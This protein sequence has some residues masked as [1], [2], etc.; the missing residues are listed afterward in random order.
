MKKILL[1]PILLLMILNSCEEKKSVKKEKELKQKYSIDIENSSVNWTAYKTT[2]KVAVKGTFKEVNIENIKSESSMIDAINGLEF[3]IPVTSIYS[4][5]TIRDAKLVKFFFGN[6]DNSM[7]LKGE[8]HLDD[9]EGGSIAFTMN[10][11]T[12][13]LPIT[14][15]IDNDIMD[16]NGVMDL[17]T[18]EAKAAI[19]ILKEACFELHKGK[20]GVSKTWEEI[21]V[22][23]KLKIISNQ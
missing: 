4:K 15:K 17:N 8:L 19:A 1:L 20:D 10:G 12:K 14:Y 5:D 11:L 9:K 13:N 21:G 3:N 6:M 23:A 7:R 16:I 18:W 22:N 2:D